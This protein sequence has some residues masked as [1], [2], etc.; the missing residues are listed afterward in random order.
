[1]DNFSIID[2]PDSSV[3]GTS[4]L[5]V[6][7]PL[8]QVIDEADLAAAKRDDLETENLILRR[9]MPRLRDLQEKDI[10]NEIILLEENLRIK[11][12]KI[13]ELQGILDTE[14]RKMTDFKEL[15]RILVEKHQEQMRDFTQKYEKLRENVSIIEEGGG[16]DEDLVSEVR[17]DANKLVEETLRARIAELETQLTSNNE[18]ILA[19]RQE[20][21]ELRGSVE[22][23]HQKLEQAE[24]GNSALG[25]EYREAVRQLQEK[26][27]QFR[28]QNKVINGLRKLLPPGI[29]ERS[30]D[31]NNVDFDSKKFCVK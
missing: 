23:F 10:T 25:Y 18:E 21:Q 7:E 5:S 17:Q 11:D 19:L 4:R 15:E 3:Y 2:D 27:Q 9:N 20:N 26:D 29:D 24:Q 30:I 12:D 8:R 31:W 1:M 14:R 22:D 16:E 28:A 13:L 6:L